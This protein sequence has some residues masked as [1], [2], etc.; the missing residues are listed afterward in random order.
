M[1]KRLPMHE[2]Q[3]LQVVILAIGAVTEDRVCMHLQ[4]QRG[5]LTLMNGTLYVPYG[6]YNG[7]CGNY[8]GVV[9]GVDLADYSVKAW[10]TADLKGGA[11]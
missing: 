6:G 8:H 7:D 3:R 9:V 2:P 1:L 4:N 11:W 10:F 5:G